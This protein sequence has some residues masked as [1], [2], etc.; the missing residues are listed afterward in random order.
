MRDYPARLIEEEAA[1]C[2]YARWQV[3]DVR[4]GE[5]EGE[6]EESRRQEASMRLGRSQDQVTAQRSPWLPPGRS[7]DHDGVFKFFTDTTKQTDWQKPGMR[8]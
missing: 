5:A 6:D 2:G 8:R 7:V 1:S 3:R 4:G